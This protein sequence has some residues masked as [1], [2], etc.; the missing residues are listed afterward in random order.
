MRC[1]RSVVAPVSVLALGI[2]LLAQAPMREGRWEITMQM[3]MPDMPVAM[4][5]MKMTQ[6]IT[7]EDLKDPGR[8]LPKG[9][10]DEAARCE[11]NHYKVDG[12]KVTWK[13][14][15][16]GPDPVTGE[17]EMTASADQYDGRMKVAAGGQEFTMKISGKRVGDCTK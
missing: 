15:C 11:I 9:P 3:Q 1:P 10:P 14:T 17:G 5:P 16:K 6:C 4:P 13:L 8:V 2:G 7:A 12:N